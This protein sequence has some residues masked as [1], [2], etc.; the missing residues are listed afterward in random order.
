MGQNQTSL[1]VMRFMRTKAGQVMHYSDIAIEVGLPGTLVNTALVRAV[2]KHPEWG[3]RRMARGEYVFKPEL[4]DI[5]QD[6]VQTKVSQMYESVGQTKDGTI[7]VRD[8]EW[9]L[10]RL[11]EKL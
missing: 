10:Y 4:Q 8:E 3:I 9:I 1:L 11:A 6:I 2:S 5:V 7:I